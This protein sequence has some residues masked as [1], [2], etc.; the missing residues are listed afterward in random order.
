MEVGSAAA[1]AG[2]DRARMFRKHCRQSKYGETPLWKHADFPFYTQLLVRAP[3]V[4]VPHVRV[5]TTSLQKWFN[6]HSAACVPSVLAVG[7]VSHA[8]GR[9]AGRPSAS[10]PNFFRLTPN[11]PVARRQEFKF[12]SRPQEAATCKYP[13][14][15]RAD[16]LLLPDTHARTRRK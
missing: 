2:G 1:T 9:P 10:R 7:V 14:R 11:L 12:H 3:A 16:E 5:R 15:T 8:A 6:Y 13:G 4:R